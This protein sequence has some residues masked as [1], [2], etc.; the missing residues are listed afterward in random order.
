M[1]TGF[2]ITRTRRLKWPLG[3]G[4]ALFLLGTLALAS[5]RRAWP[6]ALYTLCLVPSAMG[7]GFQFPGTMLALLAHSE[8]RAQAVVTSTLVL[9]RAVGGVLG[10]GLS[11]LVVQNALWH[12]LEAYVAPGPDKDALVALVRARVQAI[13]GLAPEQ[14]EQ[15]VH[16]Y[17]DAMRL[18]FLFLAAFA[19]V[20]VVF[21]VPV[22]LKRLEQRK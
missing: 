11:S 10:I 6:A 8:Q 14:R 16:S 7:Q 13:R 3:A 22:K 20:S 1:A 4:A 5:M 17:E 15:A 9:W 21:I 18:A 19:A 2:L 12:Y